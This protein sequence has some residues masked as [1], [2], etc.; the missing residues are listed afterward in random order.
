MSGVALAVESLTHCFSMGWRKPRLKAVDRLSL[1]V[2]EGTIHGLLGPN[3]SGKSTTIKCILGLIV[4]QEGKITLFGEVLPSRAIRRQIG[5]M[6]ESPY[7]PRFLTG[8]ELLDL[9]GRLCGL[10]I[11]EIRRRSGR[12]LRRV[13]MEEAADRPLSSYSKGMLQRISLAQA[14]IHEPRL[15]ILDEPT[16]GLDPEGSHEIREILLEL[17]RQGC[18]LLITSHL[19]DQMERICDDV[20]LLYRG[21]GVYSGSIDGLLKAPRGLEVRILEADV[22]RVEYYRRQLSE[23]FVEPIEVEPMRMSL[24]DRFLE[25]MRQH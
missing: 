16:A 13:R 9:H 12:L 15:V 18:T 14:L 7:F 24:E 8:R 25:M 11:E 4:P 22:S 19:L 3:G 20:T 5:Y 1:N 23:F 10:G 6:P 2:S 17:K 21:V